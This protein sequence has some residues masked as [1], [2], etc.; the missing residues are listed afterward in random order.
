MKKIFFAISFFLACATAFSMDQ[1][2]ESDEADERTPLLKE[3]RNLSLEEFLGQEFVATV[4][5]AAK[6][7]G[8]QRTSYLKIVNEMLLGKVYINS[9]CKRDRLTALYVACFYG[10]I[11]L[12]KILIINGADINKPAKLDAFETEGAYYFLKTKTPLSI[13]IKEG[14][15]EIAKLLLERDASF[16]S[17][18]EEGIYNAMPNK[19]KSW[20]PL[21]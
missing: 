7:K 17:L 13:A 21:W 4:H 8:A 20:L 15:K 1:T 12:V 3:K 16:D 14:H 5:R 9:Y 18:E 10:D 19:P 2:E 11:D 6:E